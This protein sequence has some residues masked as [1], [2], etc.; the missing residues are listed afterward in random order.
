MVTV[1]F[2]KRSKKKFEFW[3]RPLIIKLDKLNVSPH[4]L[5]LIS[6]LFGIGSV[7]FLFANWTGFVLCML[8]AI[9][10]DILDGGLARYS[11]KDSAL[12]FYLDNLNDRLINLLLLFKFCIVFPSFIVGWIVLGLFIMHY[13]LFLLFKTENVIYVRTVTVIFLALGI[14]SDLIYKLGIVIIMIM[15]F[16]GILLQMIEFRRKK[17]NI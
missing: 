2:L 17:I 6:F 8:F 12:G 14:F 13:G 15:L 7:Y 3:S 5:T 16:M 11:M 10:F 9:I 1:R 4:L